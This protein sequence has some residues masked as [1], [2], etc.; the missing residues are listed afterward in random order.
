LLFRQ[1]APPHATYLFKHALVVPIMV[2]HRLMGTSLME[3]GEIAQGRAHYNRAIALY[4]PTK[5]RSLGSR[6]GQDVRIAALGYRARTLWMLG[7]PGAGLADARE[8]LDEA[9]E[10]GRAHDFMFA[11]GLAAWVN[12]LCGHYIAANAQ[13]DEVVAL[14]NEKG[15]QFAHAAA[16]L[17][18]GWLFVLTGQASKGVTM[19]N[20]GIDAL[21]S[22]GATPGPWYLSYLARACAE[23]GQ[24][25]D[26]WR[27]ITEATATVEITKE[28][29]VE[30]EVHRM[31]GEIALLSPER[32]ETEA[33]ACFVRALSVA[34]QQQ[35][36]S[37]ELRAAMSLARLWCSQ[38]KPQQARELLA[39]V[40]GWFTEGFDTRDLK[41]AKALLD[42]L[43]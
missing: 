9:R 22:T 12:L 3:T 29:W 34:R 19:L 7:Y 28:R 24:F 35:A 38:G 5:H 27:W 41:E 4:D 13:L 15:S 37:W 11:L 36:K 23:Q 21:R 10:V 32:D 39:P 6:F 42:E 1:G 25:D 20:S 14:A 2:G 40:Y 8:G 16:T 26:A 17:A 31:S 33:E 30:A 43:A 18:Q